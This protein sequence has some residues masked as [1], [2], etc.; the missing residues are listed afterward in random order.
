[1]SDPTGWLFCTI[2]FGLHPNEVIG[3]MRRILALFMVGYIMTVCL[4]GCSKQQAQELVMP[5][6]GD[7]LSQQDAPE[8]EEAVSSAV[9]LIP[10]IDTSIEIK[11]GARIAVVSKATKGEF[12]EHIKKGMKNAVKDINAAYGFSKTD[13]I[14]MTFE[15]AEKEDDIEKQVNILDAVIAENPDAL[16]ICAGDMNSCLPQLEAAKENGIPVIAFDAS[17]SEDS[18]VDAFRA[19]DNYRIGEIGAYRLSV[20]IGKMGKVAI[21]SAQSKTQSIQERIRGFQKRITSYGDIEVVEIVYVDEVEDMVQAMQNV[22]ETYPTLEGVFCTNADI[23]DMYL[24]MKKDERLDSVAMVGV[25][26]TTRQQEAIHKGEEVGCVSQNPYAIGYQTI[27]AAVQMT[28]EGDVEVP[29]DNL[30]SPVWL[31]SRT[32]DKP[33]NADYLY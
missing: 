28:A 16:C 9:E 10:Q 29:R 12:W 6:V 13:Q 11:P 27:W 2:A 20:A 18:L 30:I 26:A 23:S 8:P 3:I 21:F 32:I 15:G 14:K 31:D 7:V 19:S 17:V 25:D 33:G 5:L 4:C 24:N 22:L 1:M